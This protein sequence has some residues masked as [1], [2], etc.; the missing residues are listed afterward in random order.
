MTIFGPRHPQSNAYRFGFGSKGLA[1]AV[2][3]VVCSC[4]SLLVLPAVEHIWTASGAHQ[5]PG[6]SETAMGTY[7]F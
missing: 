3:L 4:L 5:G 1:A 7:Y 2:V 6:A